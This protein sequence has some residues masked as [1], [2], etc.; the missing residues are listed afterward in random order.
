MKN[1]KFIK[2]LSLIA[3][4]ASLTIPAGLIISSCKQD[5]KADIQSIT[6]SLRPNFI[7]PGQSV[8]VR[9]KIYPYSATDN[10]LNWEIVDC[11]F[12]GFKIS[13]NGT[14][15]A[16]K[17]I[18]VTDPQVMHIRAS[19]AKNPEVSDELAIAITN[20]PNPDQKFIGFA[21]NEV[22]Y[23]DGDGNPASVK[24]I[25]TDTG[26]T[27]RT[28]KPIDLFIGKPFE[29]IEFVPIIG[30][31]C[32]NKMQFHLHGNDTETTHALGWVG[33]TDNYWT[34]EIPTFSV[35]FVQHMHDVMEVR[36]A[37]DESILLRIEFNVWQSKTQFTAACMHYIPQGESDY[38]VLSSSTDG[39]YDCPIRLPI[40]A[41]S[42]EDIHYETMNN[43]YVFRKPYE[44]LGDDDFTFSIEYPTERIDSDM[45]SCE[46]ENPHIEIWRE[47]DDY[48]VYCIN[49][50][51]AIDYSKF[52]AKT[53]EYEAIEPIQFRV[54]DV[55]GNGCHCD[56]HAQWIKNNEGGK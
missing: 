33:Y 27:Y 21:N 56:F 9:K 49:L 54:T 34:D 41:S 29:N 35:V 32:N 13:S 46:I 51:L 16:P 7:C 25:K 38:H 39:T 40:T 36:F 55:Y 24:I 42:T 4:V 22:T 19:D 6:L 45:I 3:S 15:T 5:S 30:K 37:C 14:I 26:N 8:K 48:K 12:E 50:K 10:K 17:D 18:T 47:Y 2:R 43:L 11:P 20:D 31:G 28:E 1:I 44:Y 52:D 23:T 53:W